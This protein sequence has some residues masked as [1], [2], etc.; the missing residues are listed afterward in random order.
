[1]RCIFASLREV[2]VAAEALLD[3]KEWGSICE[4]VAPANWLRLSPFLSETP[5]SAV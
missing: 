1:L 3:W 5:T 2:E 4:W